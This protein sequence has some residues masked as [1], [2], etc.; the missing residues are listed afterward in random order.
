MS[1]NGQIFIFRKQKSMKI[2]IMI[3][4]KE[5]LVPIKQIALDEEI[6]DYYTKL[7]AMGDATGQEHLTGQELLT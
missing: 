5:K 7:E 6:K 4:T 3:L 2:D 1:N